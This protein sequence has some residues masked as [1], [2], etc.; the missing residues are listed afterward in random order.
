MTVNG[1]DINGLFVNTVNQGEDVS[2]MTLKYRPLLPFT[3]LVA[4]VECFANVST[5]AGAVAA[6]FTVKR[7]PQ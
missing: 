6:K 2:T 7:C 3:L 4:V 1:Q 5:V